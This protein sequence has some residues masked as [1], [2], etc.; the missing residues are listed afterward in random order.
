MSVCLF[1]SSERPGR[2]TNPHQIWYGGLIYKGQVIGY[3]SAPGVDPRGQGGPKQGLESIYS[4][5][6]ETRKFFYKTKVVGKVCFSGGGSYFWARNPDLEGPGPMCFWSH[7]E[8]FSGKGYKTKVIMHLPNSKVGQ[9]LTHT[10]IP[11]SLPGVGGLN[12]LRATL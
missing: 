4:R 1:E 12:G 5:N 2:W 3:V 7:G 6:R 10:P 9:V 8:S 11:L